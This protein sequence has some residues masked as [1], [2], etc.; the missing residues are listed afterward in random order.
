MDKRFLD[1][2]DGIVEWV[3]FPN[4][5]DPEEFYIQK[6]V[7]VEGLFERNKLLFNADDGYSA[8]REFRRVASVPIHMAEYLTQHYGA[9]PFKRGNEDLAKRFYNDPDFARFRTAPG[10]I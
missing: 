3:I 1:A 7:D 6:D 9:D 2:Y 10:K 5:D 8:S 4:D